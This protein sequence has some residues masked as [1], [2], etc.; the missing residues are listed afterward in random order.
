MTGPGGAVPGWY[1]DPTGDYEQRWYDGAAWT[2]RVATG[3]F[4]TDD[5]VAP[6]TPLP[7]EE[8]VLWHSGADMLTTHRLIVASTSPGR[9]PEQ[10]EAWMVA[11]ARAR[12]SGVGDVEVTI[13][14]PGYDGRATWVLRGVAEP[15]AVA[16][17]VRKQA[18]RARQAARLRAPQPPPPYGADPWG[19][20]PP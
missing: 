4:V 17:L 16:A 8:A 11:G 18:N 10:F 20:P 5:P 19:P 12:H 9:P 1:P 2:D 7:P 6:V 3:S 14:Y 13:A 15:P